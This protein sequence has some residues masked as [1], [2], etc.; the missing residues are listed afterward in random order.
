M[1]S[2]LKGVL[3][4]VLCSI[5]WSGCGG[6]KADVPIFMMGQSGMSS[7]NADKLK[8][9]LVQRLGEAPTITLKSSP[10]F[11]VEKM[12]LQLAA[13]GNG[14]MILSEEPF[15]AVI[16]KGAGTSLDAIFD[17]KEYPS[18]VAE[19]LVDYKKPDGAKEKH[20]YGIPINQTSWMKAVGYNG[21][22]L[23]AF[24]N[25]KAP[26]FEAAKK[27]LQVIAEK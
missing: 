1:K 6:P 8:E 5:I 14:I 25:S 20:L 10:I 26:D 22:E 17:P 15:K 23:F 9:S 18:G 16:Q 27:V 3:T 4:L 24:I 11:S 7:E 19:I 12:L 2:T 13:G 21:R